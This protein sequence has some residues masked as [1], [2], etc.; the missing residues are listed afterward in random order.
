MHC[1]RS[2]LVWKR[3]GLEDPISESASFF[4]DAEHGQAFQELQSLACRL[5]VSWLAS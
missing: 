5:S 4:G 1:V 3:C 2:R